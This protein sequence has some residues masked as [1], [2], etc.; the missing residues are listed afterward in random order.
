M[1][2]FDDILAQLQARNPLPPL[3]PTEVFSREISAQIAGASERELFGDAE[4]SSEQKQAL[5]SGLLLLNDDLDASHT[6]SQN[7][8]TPTGS[9]WHAIMHRREGDAGNAN[10]WW[11][12]TGEH[13][14]FPD[15]FTSVSKY[16]Q[17]TDSPQARD[18]AAKMEREGRWNPVD[19]VRAC[20]NA[21]GDDGWL[22]GVQ[23]AEMST[24]IAW[25]RTN[26]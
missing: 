13:P 16:L 22:R 10:Y 18:Y 19:F 21:H 26:R 20:S 6:I 24:L 12:L 25:C 8:H 17:S 7:I 23:A 11:R 5:R 1:A 15:V 3:V 14:A 2:L 4:L 9:F